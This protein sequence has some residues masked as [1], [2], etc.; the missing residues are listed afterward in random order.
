MFNM[1]DIRTHVGQDHGGGWSRN[2]GAQVE[3]ANPG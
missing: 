2:I 3:Y 1:D